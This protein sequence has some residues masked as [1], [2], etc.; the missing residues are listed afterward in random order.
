MTSPLFVDGVPIAQAVAARQ[1][2]IA[3]AAM[4]ISRDAT[5]RYWSTPVRT[6]DGGV[7]EILQITFGGT[8]LVNYIA[9]ETAHF[10]HTVWPEYLDDDTGAW[11]RFLVQPASGDTPATPA[12][13]SVADSSPLRVDRASTLAG[14]HP[15]HYG[16]NHW[17]PVSWRVRPRETSRVRLVF[18]R[19]AGAPPSDPIGRPTAY[20]LGAR[21]VQ[22]GYRINSRSDVP[23]YGN[24]TTY[25]N[26]FASSTDYL[27][28]RVVFSL[29]EQAPRLVLGE[30]GPDRSWRSDPMPINYAVVCF[31]ADTRDA[32][33]L[34]Q[35]IDRWYIEP[36]TVG[37]H[38]NLYYSND[39]PDSH[40]RA[41]DTALDY[42]LAQAHGTSATAHKFPQSNQ[43][44]SLGFSHA[45]P[46]YVDID[47]AFL[48]FD[49]AK[50]WWFGLEI[51]SWAWGSDGTTYDGSPTLDRPLAS[52]GQ[53]LL[54]AVV[55][56]FEFATESGDLAV[57]PIEPAF[58][59][60]SIWKIV[61]I[62]N[63]ELA[64]DYPAG[65]TLVYQIGDNPVSQ[66]TTPVTKLA[67]RP[68]VFRLGGGPDSNDPGIPGLRMR[69]L[70]LKAVPADE[71][72]VAAFLAGPQ[73]Y[74]R[75]APYEG[76]DSH[77]T[78]DS[79]LR[80]EP[81]RADPAL[82]STRLGLFGGVGDRYDDL[83][84]TPIAR[85]YTM[86]RGFLQLPPTAA[87]YWKFEFTRLVPE[88]YESFVPTTHEVRVF[89]T[90]TV[91]QFTQMAAGPDATT[92][93]AGPGIATALDLAEINRYS[94]AVGALRGLPS[95]L[96][97]TP[98]EALVAGNPTEA[99]RI[100]QFGWVWGFQPWHVGS[101]APRFVTKT[102][103]VY[104]KISVVRR[105]KVAYFAGLRHLSAYRVDYLAADDTAQYVD[106]FD[107]MH[108]VD[109]SDGV[110]LRDGALVALSASGQA[111][112]KGFASYRQVRAVQLATQQSDPIQ[113]LL[114][115]R[116]E[117]EEFDTYWE[118]YGDAQLVPGTRRVQV[119][120]GWYARTYGQVETE[121][122]YATYGGAEGRLY[123][124]V[125]GAQPDG[126]AGG[127]VQSKPISPSSGGR[128][129][130]AVQVSADQATTAP[131]VVQIVGE[132]DNTV[133]AQAE[134]DLVPGETAKFWVGYTPGTV[135]GTP[136]PGSAGADPSFEAG[137]NGAFL[138]GYFGGPAP[139]VATSAL[140]P[141]DGAQSLEVSWGTGGRGSVAWQLTGLTIGETYRVLLDAYV[142]A[143]APD[144]RIEIEESTTGDVR[145]TKDAKM[146]L[147][148]TWLADATSH[149]VVL[150]DEVPSGAGKKCYVD[151]LRVE[152]VNRYYNAI[153][154]IKYGP[155]ENTTYGEHEM[156]AFPGDV[157]VRVAQVAPTQD[158]FTV[159]RASLFD[160]PITW[161]FSV[162][163]GQTW[164]DANEVRNNP[165]G[166]LTLPEAGSALRWRMRAWRPGAWAS[167]LAIRPWYGGLLGVRPGHSATGVSGPNRSVVDQYPAI[168]RDPM[169]QQWSLPVPRWWFNPL[170]TGP[171]PATPSIPSPP[172]WVAT[173]YP[174]T[175]GATYGSNRFYEATYP[176]TY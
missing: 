135:S 130:A 111:T 122:A 23:R 44:T 73:A 70:I 115:D 156:A 11:T 100:E 74:A 78:D 163:D 69:S 169:W 42:P 53:N 81:W 5:D 117:A 86:R 158:T 17:T 126:V 113:I 165:N 34:P 155:L 145:S 146:T 85:D 167:A 26:D 60:G 139:T 76:D 31:Y 94:D 151:M 119:V 72:S 52:F 121:T 116:F 51:D 30:T 32:A 46:S 150:V 95:T 157:Y 140:H 153:E 123:A 82:G 171:A 14:A 93:D 36:T 84:W 21:S 43:Y 175:Y 108:W 27:G 91:R 124:E 54:R 127:G 25:E 56:Q 144:I 128:L 19:T 125:E 41:S 16:P 45:F 3:T 62:Y 6:Q 10:P 105:A 170:A 8:R 134:R 96:L 71:E 101:S 97:H 18:V 142:P 120:R 160:D 136:M 141:T 112:S 80:L 148:V 90:E 39:D 173:H 65:L 24:V 58:T 162:D 174:P 149:F 1:S 104:E 159:S 103:H 172:V 7:R 66:Q 164:Y 132:A 2:R 83:V 48:Q 47:N 92:R 4:P 138:S 12:V 137:S 63:P 55:D 35:V 64:G 107:D 75:R 68:S 118:T 88:V 77:T 38:C 129:Y 40:F 166:V 152:R 87:R 147:E 106:Y 143:T 67:G 13:Y 176:A 154:G 15:Q 57:V 29:A 61:A 98:T 22:F 33:G 9:L 99:A 131:V 109:D 50:S 49:P 89:A 161:S 79:I 59:W 20:S 168:E 133:L 114:D 110:E 28:S 102:T 37:A